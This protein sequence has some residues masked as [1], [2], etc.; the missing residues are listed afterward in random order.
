MQ[1][2]DTDTLFL[3][4][5]EHLRGAFHAFWGQTYGLTASWNKSYKLKDG[6]EARGPNAARDWLRAKWEKLDFDPDAPKVEG[7]LHENTSAIESL[8]DRL[9]DKVQNGQMPV[10][11][12]FIDTR[13][14]IGKSAN[15]FVGIIGK[16]KDGKTT[17][18][19]T[20]VYNWLK[21]G[22]N[23]LYITMERDPEVVMTK[24]ALLHSEHSD[25]AFRLPSW[26]EFS[27]GMAGEED[28]ENLT[29]VLADIKARRNLPGLLDVHR[30][31]EW[32]GIRGLLAAGTHDAL[33]V[34]YVGKLTA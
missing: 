16:S 29:S 31:F 3:E 1:A 9:S 28:R 18:L 13:V 22:K 2:H 30:V 6:T 32:D 12:D 17:F 19:N 14:V 33:V 5:F 20:I 21:L 27:K 10:G 24:F 26:E 15:R 7:P 4:T 11:F 23:V 25:Y 34:D 8:I